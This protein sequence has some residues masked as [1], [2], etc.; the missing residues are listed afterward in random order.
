MTPWLRTTAAV[1]LRLPARLTVTSCHQANPAS[2]T[3]RACRARGPIAW[4][5]LLPRGDEVAEV[6]NESGDVYGPFLRPDRRKALET[7]S[8][9]VKSRSSPICPDTVGDHG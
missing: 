3:S 2:L 6:R 9:A 5:P 4:W 8:A 7:I 1:S